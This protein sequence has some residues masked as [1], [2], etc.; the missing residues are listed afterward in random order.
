MAQLIGLCPLLAL[1]PDAGR[2][3]ALA[4]TILVV[5]LL[6]LPWWVLQRH[7]SSAVRGPTTL[8][9]LAGAAGATHLLLNALSHGLHPL[10]AIGVPLVAANLALWSS[11]MNS[12]A[13]PGTTHGAG[14]TL[15]RALT[16]AATLL[17]LGVLRE[18]FAR[19]TLFATAR[20]YFGSDLP[21]P[22][23]RW[24]EAQH[25]L[26]LFAQPAGALFAL[27]GLM[28]ALQAWRSRTPSTSDHA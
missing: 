9:V 23:L 28:A 16:A 13:E 5:A 18:L 26:L 12:N 11:T 24:S 2:A 20:E 1:A 22:A 14:P 25:G 27:A 17:L 4:L 21:L 15:H 10:T 6:S 19:G 3:L 8:L 7:A